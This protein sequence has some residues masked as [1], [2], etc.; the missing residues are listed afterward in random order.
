MTRLVFD[1]S[2]HVEYYQY[3]CLTFRRIPS[4]LNRFN[5]YFRIDRTFQKIES[6]GYSGGAL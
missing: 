1:G 3:G 6:L 4:R 2:Y 5:F